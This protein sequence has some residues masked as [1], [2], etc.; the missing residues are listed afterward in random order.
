MMI[1]AAEKYP[2]RAFVRIGPRLILIL[3]C[4]SPPLAIAAG[5]L[6]APQALN[7]NAGFDSGY[8]VQAEPVSDGAG[9]WVVV[10]YGTDT[11]GA[12]V[13]TD[14]DI[15]FSRSTDNGVTWSAPEAL[16]SNAGSDTGYD[17]RPEVATNGSGVWICVWRSNEDLGGA[18]DAD[19]DILAAISTDNAATW[20]APFALNENADSDALNNHDID[21]DIQT[22]GAGTWIATWS[23]FFPTSVWNMNAW[24]SRSTDNGGTWSTPVSVHFNGQSSQDRHLHPIAR[25]TGGNNW[26]VICHTYNTL[27]GSI[28]SDYDFVVSRST[29]GGVSWS[30]VSA[31]LPN[32]AGD[33][34]HDWQI[35][36]ATDGANTWVAVWNSDEP[37]V[38]SIGT[39]EDV[40][41]SR[42]TDDGVTWSTPV[43]VWSGLGSDGGIIDQNPQVATDGADNWVIVWHSTNSVGG[44]GGDEDVLFVCST[45]NG[46]TWSDA[47]PFNSNAD[48]DSGNDAQANIAA[49]GPYDFIGVWQSFD[50]LGGTIDTDQDI[51]YGTLA[52][53]TPALPA[54]SAWGW[55]GL[56]A[57][58]SIAVAGRI[59]ARSVRA[60]SLR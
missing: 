4:T 3:L 49:L 23:S 51:L 41:V 28:G 45:D 10:W 52:F 56:A 1:K 57:L 53:P 15:L 48:S 26:M 9:T 33:S 58:M 13:G 29:N 35:E 32:A 42:S 8:D 44:S 6:S 54:T 19:D 7:T 31:L 55:G 18:L 39:D 37:L 36:L 40:L 22:D 5:S 46:A 11:L 24:V 38:P 60:R 59:Y 20:G 50:S 21:P 43:A 16:N 14:E 25:H 12:T 17:R 34:G 30:A 27:G 47:E 2:N